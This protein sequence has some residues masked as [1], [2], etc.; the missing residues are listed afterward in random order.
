MCVCVC[1]CVCVLRERER[2][3]KTDRQPN[4]QA[5]RDTERVSM[6]PV[7][8]GCERALMPLS[9]IYVGV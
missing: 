2:K 3:R 5:D 1:V 9:V 8:H 4:R 7:S 6:F